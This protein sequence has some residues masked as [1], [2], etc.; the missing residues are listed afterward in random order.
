MK[1]KC[2]RENSGGIVRQVKIG[3]WAKKI[4][5]FLPGQGFLLMLSAILSFTAYAR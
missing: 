4:G 3:G 5:E 1:D 2:A